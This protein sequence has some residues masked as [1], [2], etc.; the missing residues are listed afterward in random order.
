MNGGRWSYTMNHV[1]VIIEM[2]VIEGGWE[3]GEPG[4]HRMVAVREESFGG[5]GFG[6][7]WGGAGGGE[8]LLITEHNAEDASGNEP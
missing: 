7:V 5:G 4:A 2:E 6:R 3:H 8:L 1:L